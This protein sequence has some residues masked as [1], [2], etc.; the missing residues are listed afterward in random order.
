MFN[1]D[2][3]RDFFTIC[4]IHAHSS[5]NNAIANNQLGNIQKSVISKTYH[6]FQDSSGISVGY[7]IWANTGRESILHY[8]RTNEIIKNIDQWDEGGIF[9]ILDIRFTN[10]FI[11]KFNL[12]TLKTL[13]RKRKIIGYIK[14]E[15]IILVKRCGKFRRSISPISLLKIHEED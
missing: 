14:N 9:F 2:Q 15:S 11:D 8:Q 5:E 1:D 12:K 13:L 6:I 7:I 4:E 10:L 3:F